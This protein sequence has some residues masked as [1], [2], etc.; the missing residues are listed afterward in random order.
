MALKSMFLDNDGTVNPAHVIA[1]V[2]T[3]ASIF[4]V[5]YLVIHNGEMPDLAGVAYLLGGSG[6]IN[7]AH[8]MEDIVANF[9]NKSQGS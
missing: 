5:T 7:V 6:A 4:W 9:R 3:F 1:A 2:L 8:K